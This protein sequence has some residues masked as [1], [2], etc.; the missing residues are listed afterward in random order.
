[1]DKENLENINDKAIKLKIQHIDNFIPGNYVDAMDDAKNWCIAEIV[2]RK[3]NYI[4][5]HYEGWSSKYDE[6]TL[7]LN[8]GNQY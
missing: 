1:M 5:V 8:E 2:N 3:G 4:R 6:V 7:I